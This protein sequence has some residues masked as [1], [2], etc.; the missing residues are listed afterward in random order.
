MDFI[1]WLP[2]LSYSA[3]RAY[4]N[5]QTTVCVM[6]Q[7]K[8]LMK[9]TLIYEPDTTKPAGHTSY[10]AEC[11][12]NFYWQET[13][14]SSSGTFRDV[15]SSV[16][17][18]VLLWPLIN[19]YLRIWPLKDLATELPSVAIPLLIIENEEKRQS[20]LRFDLSGLFS[21]ATEFGIRGRLAWL[22]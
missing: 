4:L 14:G 22:W 17:R 7:P 9:T 12:T 13:V 10:P 15:S 20:M 5:D 2:E 16:F 18:K 1:Q 19:R 3:H 21:S 11:P 8:E 6:N